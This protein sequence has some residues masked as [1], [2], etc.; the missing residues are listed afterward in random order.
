MAALNKFNVDAAMFA[1]CAPHIGT[2]IRE[3]GTMTVCKGKPVTSDELESLYMRSGDFRIM[4]ALFKHD[5][6]IKMC[7]PVQ[8]G[9]YD[10]FMANK[11]V[12]NKNF[13]VS[14]MDGKRTVAPFIKARQFSP[15]NNQYW[16]FASGS[17]AGTGD[18]RIV[19]ST[20]TNIP[21]DANSTAA[22]FPAR[23][24]SG[25]NTV[26]GSRVFLSN[27]TAGGTRT[28]TAWEVLVATD[29]GNGT[30]T[31]DLASK[32]AGSYQ[33]AATLTFPV[34]GLLSRGPPN[35]NAYEKWC[36]EAPT[37]RN[38]KMVLFFFEETRHT[39]CWSEKYHQWKRM[40]LSGNGLYSEF[41]N[42][43]EAQKN[44]Q[45]GKDWQDR[46]T[47]QIFF[48]K[49]E[50]FQNENQYDLLADIPAFDGSAFGL[51]VDGGSCVGK[52]ASVVGIHEQMAQCGRIAQAQ[53]VALNLPALFAEI[54]NMMRVRKGSGRQ[55]AMQFDIFTDS[56]YAELFS[57]AMLK[58]YNSKSD[59][60]LR[61]TFDIAG[62]ST[63]KKADFGF[64]FK[65]FPLNWPQGVWINVMW[66]EYFDDYIAAA[67]A[68]T[69][70]GPGF[71]NVSTLWVIDWA[72]IYPGIIQTW[73][74]QPKV[75]DLAK[76]SAIN[77]DFACVGKTYVQ[78]QTMFGMVYTVIVECPKGNMI[79]EGLPQT[80]PTVPV[81][82][83]IAYPGTHSSTTTTT[84]TPFS[85]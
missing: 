43:D 68:T 30:A 28:E 29:N 18:W 11:I 20:A 27:Y 63:T 70:T 16:N 47:N 61:T 22:T 51:G 79:I 42:L 14:E 55:N 25:G 19:V 57:Q 40:V 8:N 72:G 84:N 77:A 48:G 65:S 74:K 21:L 5:I 82:N 54:Y 41:F 50:Q 59:N 69:G 58:Y 2:N 81:D 4:D 45:L 9:L 39:M 12:T 38:W 10:F 85:G 78:Q 80:I 44:K 60:T 33:D 53:G 15:I 23:T 73:R 7:E 67:T 62:Y 24:T 71:T 49:G 35:V 52:R 83:N 3:C 66:H 13:T 76:L 36:A 26:P 46:I 31:L 32:N 64:Y 17:A 6:E 56:V 1:K 75:G 34:K 37:Y